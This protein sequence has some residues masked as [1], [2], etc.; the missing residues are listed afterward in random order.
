MP[1][2]EDTIPMAEPLPDDA[3]PADPIPFAEP[4][5]DAE[6]IVEEPA[7]PLMPPQQARPAATPVPQHETQV[8][9]LCYHDFSNLKPATDMRINTEAFRLQMQSLKD[10]GLTVITMADFLEWKLGARQLPEKCVMI[11]ID[12]GW[13]S[14]YTDAY[15]ILKNLGLPFTIFP[16]TSF[17]SG[18]GA[19]M[20]PAQ[21]REMMQNGA[22]VGSHSANHLYPRSWKNAKKKG[23]EELAALAD[24]EI[25][26]SKA[27]LTEKLP[28]AAI[29][30]YCY[31]GGFFTPEMIAKVEESG[32]QAAFTVVPK[33]VTKDTDRWKIHRYVVLGKEP[34]TF[35][36]AITFQPRTQTAPDSA[37]AGDSPGN[38]LPAPLQPVTPL[39]NAVLDNNT[40]DIGI[41]LTDEANLL[42]HTLEMRVSGFGIVNA[43]FNPEDQS[44]KWSPARHLRSSPVTVHV[45][46]KIKGSA[47][48]QQ[49]TWQFGV[50]EPDNQYLPKNLVR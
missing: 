20:N 21:I 17:I 28:G 22:T 37:P 38:T 14:V 29:D 6:P 7:E 9:I 48:W 11:T 42:P 5:P 34:N 4:I 24:K 40:P 27:T 50:K 19:S 10:S 12:D 23:A 30:T 39:A 2:A 3:I 44:F 47:K 33:K 32:Y 16:Y 31:P 41:F 26:D 1:A 8:A 35:T 36:R 13:K 18:A 46:W 15:P 43:K 49:A 25:K 45:R